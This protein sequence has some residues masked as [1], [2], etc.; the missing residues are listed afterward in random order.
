VLISIVNHSRK[1]R[2]RDLQVAVRAINR[3][4]R[5]D[6]EPYWNRGGRLRLEGASERQ[7]RPESASDLRGEAVVYFCDDPGDALDALGYH[8]VNHRGI[9][10]GFVFRELCAELREP[11]SVTLSH[12][13]LELVIDPEANLLV[14]GPHPA[15]PTREVYHWYE[16]CDAVQRQRYQIDGVAVSN[17]VL[18]LYFTSRE[19]R[20]GRNDFLGARGRTPALASFGVA[21]GGYVGFFDPE[22][23]D[24]DTWFADDEARR[25]RA[26]KARAGLAQRAERYRRNAA[27]LG[28]FEGLVGAG[29]PPP[30]LEAIAL[31]LRAGPGA[32]A[33]A[34]A[35]AGPLGR[36]WRAGPVAASALELDLVPPRGREPAAP[37]AWELVY[38]LRA[39]AALARVE[40]LFAA[41]LPDDEA[42]Q[43]VIA[44]KLGRL[45]RAS[46]RSLADEAPADPDWSG[47]LAQVPQAHAL[48]AAAGVAPGAGVRIAH[49][50]TGCTPH[51][52]LPLAAI[53]RPRARDFVDADDDPTDPLADDAIEAGALL[54][55]PGH[56][57]ATGSVLVSPRGAQGPGYAAHVSGVAPAAKLVPLRVAT[58]VVQ[59]S[60]RNLRDALD[61]AV[62][63]DCHVV[64]IS[65]GG[66][67][68]GALHAA[69]G[70]A[71]A[72][73]VIVV[74]AAGNYVRLVVW[75]AQY[76]EVVAVAA[77]DERGRPW[78]GSSR[79]CA[80][81][82]TGPGQGV[83]RA[84]WAPDGAGGWRPDVL[85]SDGT[86]YATAVVAGTAA[87]WLSYH[88]RERLAARYPGALLPLAFRT[89]VARTS[90]AS[91][92]LAAGFGAGRL[93]AAA[94]LRAPLPPAAS[95]RAAAVRGRR[96][97]GARAPTRGAP[98]PGPAAQLLSLFEHHDPA[99]ARAGLAEILGGELDERAA[100]FGNELTFRLL[101]DPALHAAVSAQLGRV[102]RA[103]ASPRLRAE[104]RRSAQAQAH[105]REVRA[106]LTAT[107]LSRPLLAA[108]WG[109]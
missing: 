45:L 39:L 44:A 37:E 40:P 79:G 78:W 60:M 102:A 25:R 97:R 101:L 46:G 35:L 69:I 5:D 48:L 77:C 31:A 105:V 34:R 99:V 108:I 10:Y 65:L 68:S 15:D 51:P 107:G 104:R 1:V 106:A 3:Q 98:A 17:F 4:L 52:E 109:A 41:R 100:R 85:P 8:E 36:G 16:V 9:A 6:F 27:P 90:V 61:W 14:K 18:P 87:L 86:S 73:G 20:G 21:P 84:C 88:G 47:R 56:G 66:L 55:S 58:S 89:L 42:R 92:E 33:E 53:D 103:Q 49:P 22:V 82:V 54:P 7:P 75:P 93:D 11:W 12:E 74:A 32:A 83:Y 50:D 13:V 70:R 95:L 96:T 19:E 57:T 80:V 67:P 26:I 64:S 30:R 72:R 38:R 63:R 94:L 59:H 81:D 2:D 76:D 24:Q 43:E 29:A 28:Y 91:P 23:G 62:A 71:V